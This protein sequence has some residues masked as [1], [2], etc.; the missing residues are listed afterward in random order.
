MPPRLLRTGRASRRLPLSAVPPPPPPPPPSLSPRHSSIC[1]GRHHHGSDWAPTDADDVRSGDVGPFPTGLTLRSVE[2]AGPPP[3]SHQWRRPAGSS[4]R[5]WRL[6]SPPPP[7]RGEIC[8]PA[9]LS[10]GGGWA[11]GRAGPAVASRRIGARGAVWQRRLGEERGGEGRASWG[12]HAV[13]ERGAR[14]RTGH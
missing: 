5:G 6:S 13:A 12:Q 14:R 7:V 8:V 4:S 10:G 2:A 11:P 1:G 9:P 3:P